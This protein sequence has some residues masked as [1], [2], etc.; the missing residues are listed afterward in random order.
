M[1]RFT[2]AVSVGLLIIASGAS[3][4]DYFEDKAY[5]YLFGERYTWRQ[6]DG[7][8]QITKDVGETVG[9]G[10]FGD[11]QV[12]EDTPMLGRLRGEVFGG[13]GNYDIA[14]GTGS[15]T[16]STS[17]RFGL[18]TEGDLGWRFLPSD[19]KVAILPFGGIGYRLWKR[20][21]EGTQ[22]F[23]AFDESWHDVYTKAGARG[24]YRIERDVAL[25]AEAGTI[26]PVFTRVSG[27]SSGSKGSFKPGMKV[28]TFA[29]AGV[30]YKGLRPSIY[31]EG[32]R[33]SAD[34]SGAIGFPRTEGDVFGLRVAFE[35]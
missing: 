34:D 7:G 12:A 15:K 18:R 9:I 32:S 30:D 5:W 16:S 22:A 6:F 2:L 23:Q 13:R 8:T 24:Q 21:V 1:R 17:N 35:F 11:Y 4:R 26:L 20:N 19:G 14:T 33:F 31:Y 28:S 10:A 3:A 25:F 27:G 29:E